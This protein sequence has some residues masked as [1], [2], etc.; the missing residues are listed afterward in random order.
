MADRDLVGNT[1]ATLT[2]FAIPV[3]ICLHLLPR[4]TYQAPF[5]VL[6]SRNKKK[7]VRADGNGTVYYH[8]SSL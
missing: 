7:A 3:P 4:K 2:T 6:R 8:S 1:F 5:E